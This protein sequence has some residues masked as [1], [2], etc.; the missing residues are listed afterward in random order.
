MKEKRS[1]SELEACWKEGDMAGGEK[2]RAMVMIMRT[3]G[4]CWVKQGGCT[5]CGYREASL[6][7]V[8]PD[9]LL[10]QLEQA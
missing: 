3:N 4:C 10:K 8:T 2:V 6:M 9:D 7:N 1:P 5:M